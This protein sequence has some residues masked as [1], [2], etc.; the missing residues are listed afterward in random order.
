LSQFNRWLA[1]RYRAEAKRRNYPQ[2]GVARAVA[3]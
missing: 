3:E 2:Y 1:V